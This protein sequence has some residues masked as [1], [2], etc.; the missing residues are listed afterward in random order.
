MISFYKINEDVF[1]IKTGFEGLCLE[2]SLKNVS[3]YM[4][5]LTKR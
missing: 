1:H 4:P 5:R 3:E 2:F